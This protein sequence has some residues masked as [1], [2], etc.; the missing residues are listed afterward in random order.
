MQFDN[1]REP[2]AAVVTTAAPATR[3]RSLVP[4]LLV[5]LLLSLVVLAGYELHTSYYSAPKISQYA[6]TLTYQLQQGPAKQVVYPQA[7][8]FDERHGYSR[9]PELLKRLQERNFI[10]TAQAEFS[11]T[12]Q[13]YASQGFFPPYREKVQS[14]LFLADCRNQTLFDFNYPQ[15]V[16][17]D[18][19]D[20]PTMV[21]HS[22]L[23]IE[24]RN[25]LQMPAMANP[26][27]DWPRFV[28][29]ALSQAG[30]IV[31]MGGQSAGGSTLATQIEKFRH[32]PMGLTQSFRDKA[33][34]IISGTI[35]VYQQG[36]NTMGMRTR[37]VQDY[38]NT[39]PLSSAPGHGEVHGI[40]DALWAWFGSDF[41]RAN[42]LLRQPATAETATE[43]AQ[44]FRQVV[45][46]MIAQRRPSYYLL[47]GHDDLEQLIN[48][49]IRLL[50]RAKIIDAPLR[51]LALA[52]TLTFRTA[53]LNK[54]RAE[55]DA[56]KGVN[57]ARLRL[58]N[59]LNQPMY[60]LDRLDLTA[61]STIHGDVQQK[62]SAYLRSLAKPEIAGQYGLLGERLLKASGT[63]EVLYS[64]YAV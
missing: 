20:I 46:L 5:L 32:S 62:V 63:A 7:G 48:S 2:T 15:R 53:K 64:F 30:K 4:W 1:Y 41:D 18:P 28:M 57:A 51:D 49:H 26:V 13:H 17:R 33:I 10:I 44:Y 39:V 61:R 52:Q 54:S 34:Q 35:R 36:V 45:A 31:G 8:P 3:R 29:A 19:R 23:F 24:N 6:S 25:L 21:A 11:P 58:G 60:D 27:M 12:L 37:I 16:Y 14:G 59:L 9:L 55:Q 22:L 43:R 40:G 42:Q 50:A 38:L 56:R 47:Q